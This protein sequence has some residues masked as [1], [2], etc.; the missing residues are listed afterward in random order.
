[1]KMPRSIAMRKG[2]GEMS[3]LS[4]TILTSQMVITT[5]PMWDS[6]SSYR[7]HRSDGIYLPDIQ[8]HSGKLDKLPG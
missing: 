4:L 1:M 7:D 3:T 8:P 5:S 2:C 6:A